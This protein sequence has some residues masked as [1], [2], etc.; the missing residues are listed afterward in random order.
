MTTILYAGSTVLAFA[1]AAVI[2]PL[3]G[4][5]A[6]RLGMMDVPGGR[7]LHPRPIAQIGR[8]HV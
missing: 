7:R 3:V 2:T 8:A 1:L 5:L 4:R 6:K